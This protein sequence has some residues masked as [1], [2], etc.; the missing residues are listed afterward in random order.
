VVMSRVECDVKRAATIA[1]SCARGSATA[2]LGRVF[3]RITS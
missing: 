3:A 1:R 2:S